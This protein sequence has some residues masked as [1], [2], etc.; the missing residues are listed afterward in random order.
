[1]PRLIIMA[2]R[3]SGKLVNV[4]GRLTSIGRA[5]TNAVVLDDDRVSRSHAVIDWNGDRFTVTD[6]DSSN[7]T[8]VNGERVTVQAL[9]HG[10]T[11]DMGGC[12]M[13]FYYDKATSRMDS[14][15]LVPLS[16]LEPAANPF[17][18]LQVRSP[19][20]ADFQRA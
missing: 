6:L 15:S 13:R 1:M 17:V 9:A 14:L 19:V 11:I 2:S 4:T 7:G 10:D 12:T 18:A 16:E 20:V 5:E 8:Y 3:Q